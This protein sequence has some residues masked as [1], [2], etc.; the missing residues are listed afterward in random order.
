MNQPIT[1]ESFRPGTSRHTRSVHSLA[2]RIAEELDLHVTEEEQQR[3]IGQANRLRELRARRSQRWVAMQLGITDRAVQAW[4]AGGGI[5][6]ENVE[7]LAKLYGVTPDFIEHGVD[8][9]PT[10]DQVAEML[11]LLRGLDERLANVEKLLLER[12]MA[13]LEAAA[14]ARSRRSSPGTGEAETS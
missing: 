11:T 7:A 2:L 4:E 1:K 3:L 12:E 5:S 14:Q 6:G 13:D 10:P 8:R 9:R